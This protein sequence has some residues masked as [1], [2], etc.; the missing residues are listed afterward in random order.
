VE[1]VKFYQ[2]HTVQSL[3]PFWQ[4][5]VDTTQGGIFTCFDNHGRELL[6]CN[7]YT[8]SQGRFVWLWSRLSW[9]V[10]A[11]LLPG[12]AKKYLEEAALAV[13]FLSRHAF[14]PNGNC[15]FLLSESGSPIESIPGK[16]YD[17]S[18]YADC[19]V[20]LG[21]SEYARVSGNARVL[22]SAFQLYDSIVARIQA[23]DFRS[24]PYPVPKGHQAH[25]IT[26]IL[27]RI[28]QC[29]ADS[30]ASLSHPR[31]EETYQHMEAYAQRILDVFLQPEG[32]VAEMLPYDE[33][34][35]GTL[36][37]RHVTPGH[38][39]E[40]MWFIMTAA[41]KRNRPQWIPVAASAVRKA[42]ML[43]WDTEDGGLFRMVDRDGGRPQGTVSDDPFSL[44][45]CDTWDTKIWWPHI[46]GLYA[47]LLAHSLTGDDDFL[48]MHHQLHEYVFRTFPNPET[49]IGEWI[50]IRDR[51]GN[52]IE[53]VVALPVKDPYHILQGVMLMVDLLGGKPATELRPVEGKS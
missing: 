35:A 47:T 50:Q 26:M 41:V 39:L 25:G 8:W 52:P 11:G 24:E 31:A 2:D 44:L 4:R 14:L 23:G 7:K 32:H 6:S 48:A 21:F 43:G 33:K 37:A 28:A 13:D 30:A 53:K 38:T 46:E 36:L 49:E 27:L 15:A 51:K 34:D 45:I 20:V 18:V 17:T 12:D 16:G 29:L 1:L 40:C 9:L 10:S 19:F 5:A 3:L 22:E 42:Y